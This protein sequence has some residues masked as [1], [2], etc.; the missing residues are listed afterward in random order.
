MHAYIKKC[1]GGIIID[2]Q[3]GGSICGV[4]SSLSTH[5]S[6]R[7]NIHRVFVWERPWVWGVAGCRFEGGHLVFYGVEGFFFFL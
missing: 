2:F 6:R 7:V 1:G 4:A 3:I 5:K